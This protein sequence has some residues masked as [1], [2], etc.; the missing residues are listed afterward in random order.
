MGRRLCK[1][2]K[3]GRKF[4][5]IGGKQYPLAALDALSRNSER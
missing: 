5:K 3:H 4:K 1:K 2:A